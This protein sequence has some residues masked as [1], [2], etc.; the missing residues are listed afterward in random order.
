MNFI[1]FGKRLIL[2]ISLLFTTLIAQAQTPVITGTVTDA[3]DKEPLSFVTVSFPGSTTGV[4]TKDD[5]TYSIPN[6]GN[7]TQ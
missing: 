4:Q 3:N 1:S 2:L 5:G 6:T 7:H